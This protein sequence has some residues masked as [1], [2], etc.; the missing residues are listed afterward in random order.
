ME[1]NYEKCFAII[2]AGGITAATIFTVPKHELPGK[3]PHFEE[4]FLPDKLDNNCTSY[5]AT[6][7]GVV[8]L[9]KDNESH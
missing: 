4:N 9:F 7:I 5:T 8:Y 1:R 2:L 6:G 3:D